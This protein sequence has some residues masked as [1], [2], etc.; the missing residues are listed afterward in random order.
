MSIIAPKNDDG[1]I[2]R[3]NKIDIPIPETNNI[4]SNK[5]NT[6][7]INNDFFEFAGIK[8]FIK[9]SFLFY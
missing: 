8:K 7:N 9:P 3:S 4:K 6:P 2:K 5:S 1:L